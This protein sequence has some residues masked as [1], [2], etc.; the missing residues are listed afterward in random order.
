[1]W[2]IVAIK[3]PGPFPIIFLIIYTLCCILNYVAIYKKMEADYYNKEAD[4]INRELEE[5]KRR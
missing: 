4:K 1:M 5:Y 2:C 3:Y